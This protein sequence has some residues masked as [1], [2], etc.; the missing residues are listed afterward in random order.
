MIIDGVIMDPGEPARTVALALTPT[1]DTPLVSCI[2]ATR[3]AIEPARHA[4]DCYRRQ[5]YPHRELILACATPNSEVAHHVAG[6]AGITVV[7]MRQAGSVGALRNAAIA[8]AAGSLLCVWDD[9]DLSHPQRLDW[10]VSAMIAAEADACALARVLLWWPDRARL[11]VSASRTWEN[12]LLVRAAAMPV[13]PDMTRGGDTILVQAL[14]ASRR[15]VAIDRPT[16][17]CYVAH[18]ANLWG[19]AH[20]ERLFD[21]ATEDHGGAGYAATIDSLAGMLPFRAYAGGWRG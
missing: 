17:Y 9:D 5:T 4:I 14:R 21:C 13:Y 7:E 6:E 12:S 8:V 16:A 19:A 15:L 10:Q 18:G 3:G 11:A 1:S 2:M 20:F